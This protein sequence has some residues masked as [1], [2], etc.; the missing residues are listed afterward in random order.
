VKR[1]KDQLRNRKRGG[2]EDERGKKRWKSKE[3]KRKAKKGGGEKEEKNKR[4]LRLSI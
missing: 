4:F 3:K 1:R 2:V